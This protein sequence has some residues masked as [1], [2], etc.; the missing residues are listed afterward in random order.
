MTLNFASNKVLQKAEGIC[1]KNIA[2][3]IFPGAVCVMF[4]PN[5]KGFNI[6]RGRYT[7]QE[8]SPK[9]GADTIFDLASFTKVFTAILVMRLQELRLIDIGDLVSK[10]IQKLDVEGKRQI[11]LRHILTHTSGFGSLP[12]QKVKTMKEPGELIKAMAEFDLLFHPGS[13]YKYSDL[14]YILLGYIIEDVTGKSL[15]K[16]LNEWIV[17]PLDLNS[18][19]YNPPAHLKEKIAPTETN[20]EGGYYQGVVHDEK[21]RLLGGVAGHSGIFSTG[22]DITKLLATFLEIVKG[23]QNSILKPETAKSMIAP[24]LTTLNNTQGIGW[25]LNLPYMGKLADTNTFGHTGF[26]GVSALVNTSR[27]LGCVVLSNAVHPI[28]PDAV[29]RK[30]LQVARAELADLTLELFEA[31]R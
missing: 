5:Q 27:E 24:Q 8:N 23:K 13:D 31:N 12:K 7:Y 14:G 4:L 28:R 6:Y 19:L 16:C 20:Y 3:G 2:Q 22:D 17:M 11:T 30:K 29:K 15:D 10:Y 18:T 26:T 21:A 1:D 9:T 25:F